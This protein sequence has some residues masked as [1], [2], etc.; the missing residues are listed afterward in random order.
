VL[1]ATHNNEPQEVKCN[2]FSSEAGAAD[3]A[4]LEQGVGQVGEYVLDKTE[5]IVITGDASTMVTLSV[6]TK[7]PSSSSSVGN[8]G[9]Q[10]QGKSKLSSPGGGKSSHAMRDDDDATDEEEDNFMEGP[11]IEMSKKSAKL[12]AGNPCS[13]QLR[14]FS[15]AGCGDWSMKLDA[16]GT[17]LAGYQLQDLQLQVFFFASLLF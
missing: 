14:A 6:E 11:L 2:L 3:A 13:I 12:V 9:G 7:L 5:D 1:L 4:A 10:G 8:G 15:L 16:P 17:L